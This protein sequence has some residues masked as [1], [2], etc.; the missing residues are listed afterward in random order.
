MED[1]KWRQGWYRRAGVV[2]FGQARRFHFYLLV[3][4]L[5]VYFALVV[6]FKMQNLKFESLTRKVKNETGDEKERSKNKKQAN[7]TTPTQP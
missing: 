1:E 5:D 4:M 7:I 3:A 6:T 2:C